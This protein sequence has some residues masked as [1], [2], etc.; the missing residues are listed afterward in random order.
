MNEAYLKRVAAPHITETELEE[1]VHRQG[2]DIA[3]LIVE[4]CTIGGNL[5]QPSLRLS[6]ACM[7]DGSKNFSHIL[8]D[9]NGF[10]VLSVR[11]SGDGFYHVASLRH[12]DLKKRG[13]DSTIIFSKRVPYLVK[14]IAAQRG[15]IEGTN[16]VAGMY[17]QQLNNT[18]SQVVNKI[19]ESRGA[20]EYKVR[21]TDFYKIL[22]DVRNNQLPDISLY[23]H[24]MDELEEKVAKYNSSAD[25][26]QSEFL[27]RKWWLVANYGVY[28]FSVA[29]VIAKPHVTVHTVNDQSLMLATPPTMYYSFKD[30]EARAPE[31]YSQL[32]LQMLLTKHAIPTVT[33]VPMY[34]KSGYPRR[35]YDG[36]DNVVPDDSHIYFCP[37]GDF[38]IPEVGCAGWTY[39][40]S[41]PR[42]PS[43]CL[44]E[45]NV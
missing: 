45:R 39:N 44:F 1:L 20:N 15:I 9:K 37:S 31:E 19:H 11:T 3:R 4:L 29:Q 7:S 32:Y 36:N 23:T 40:S 41:T 18:A 30:M 17:T 26:I 14:S 38:Y 42:T 28:G 35:M 10:P 33:G 6:G 13:S 22:T 21:L 12:V 43:W 5:N 34:V 8:S 16:Y 27:D 24:I 25:R 2:H